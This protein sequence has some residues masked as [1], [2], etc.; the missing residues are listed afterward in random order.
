[1]LTVVLPWRPQPSRVAAFDEVHAWYTANL[2]EAEI[3][4]VDSGDEP[5]NLARCRNLGVAQ[6]AERSETER[7]G[8]GSRSAG[9]ADADP[10][11]DV[12]VIGDADT[13][14]Q[15]GPLREAIVAARTSGR[16]HLPYTEYHWLGR[17]G[18]A[19]FR[20]GTALE[21]CDFELIAGAC[22][23]VYVTTPE[24][25]WRHGG[26][27]ER[28]RGWGFEDAAWYVAHETLLGAPP[29]RH[30]GSVFALHHETQLREGPQYDLNAALMQRYRD[31]AAS[32]DAMRALVAPR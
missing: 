1:M 19:E 4:T 13:M 27:D 7:V 31:A 6:A 20:A 21:A 28:F 16:V 25:W 11:A 18:T 3:V 23:G 5:F 32:P 29:Q 2:P 30:D 15:Q 9:R 24:T 8:V 12:V 14:P 10:G 22:S 17:T 26:Q